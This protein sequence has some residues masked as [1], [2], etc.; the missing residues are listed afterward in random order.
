MKNLSNTIAR[1]F[2]LHDC[3]THHA[4][5][6]K[7][8]FFSSGSW[9]FWVR[10]DGTVDVDDETSNGELPVAKIVYACRIAAVKYLAR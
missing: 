10:P 1:K 3:D 8:C 7:C 6:A 5:D 2:F 9:G 4:T